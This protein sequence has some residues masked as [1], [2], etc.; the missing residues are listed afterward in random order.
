MK[1]KYSSAI[2]ADPNK[3]W[4]KRPILQIE[5]FGPKESKK[6]YALIDSGADC[7]LFNIQVARV[8]GFDLSKAKKSSVVGIES[9]EPIFTYLFEN[10]ETKIEGF[11]K[12][13]KI[14]V[15][16]IDSE[17][18]SLLLGEEGFFDQ[19][20]IK[21]EKDHDAFEINPVKN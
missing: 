10:V 20:R 19:C 6:F 8:L 9:A 3:T 4:V 13:I 16:F 5:I 14:P 15:N 17:S 18:V 7:S 12:K 2:P 11:D 1:Y 21:F